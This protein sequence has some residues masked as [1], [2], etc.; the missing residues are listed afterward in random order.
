M[1]RRAIHRGEHTRMMSRISKGVYRFTTTDT[2]FVALEIEEPDGWRGVAV[3]SAEVAELLGTEAQVM[4]QEAMRRR[5]R[6]SYY[7]AMSRV[8]LSG[9]I[10]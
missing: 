7:S 3:M 5:A 10:S 1:T 9:G 4:A 8:D 6:N 2:G